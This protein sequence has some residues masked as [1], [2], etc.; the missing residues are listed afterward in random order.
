MLSIRSIALATTA[1]AALVPAAASANT[2][3]VSKLDCPGTPEW[4][5]QDAITDASNDAAAARIEIGPGVFSGNIVVPNNPAGLEIVGSGPESTIFEATVAGTP[6]IE[7][8][9]ASLSQLG[10]HLPDV[11]GAGP[12]A[13]DLVDGASADHIRAEIPGTYPATAVHIE[14]GGSLSHAYIDAGVRAAVNIGGNKGYADVAIT[15]TFLRGASPITVMDPQHTVVGRRDHLVVTQDSSFGIGVA[16]GTARLE[17]SVVD[18]RG[19]VNASAIAALAMNGGPATVEGRHLTVLADG[20]GS[21]GVTAIS[22]AGQGLAT[23]ALTDSVLNGVKL[24]AKRA[25]GGSATIAAKRVDTWPAA[26][27]DVAGATFSDEGSFS[28]DPL[29][30]ADLVPGAGSPAIDAAA[31][32]GD[33][34]SDTDLAGNARALD[35][36]GNCDARPDLGAYEAPAGTCVPPVP[37]APPA[38]P[39]IV[40]APP[41]VDTVAPRVTKLSVA[42]RRAVRFTLTETARVTVRIARGHHKP[43]FLHRAAAGGRVTLKLKHVLRHGR[44]AIRVTAVDAAGNRSVPAVA[45]RRI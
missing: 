9:G 15:D 32:L 4:T 42:H 39:S 27:D 29:L 36:D 43:L 38:P 16:S 20:N 25:G 26:P 35:G 8:H 21:A 34:E 17:D 7:A 1:A 22:I 10:F 19:Q 45:R 5:I 24:R 12:W 18:L 3:C 44:Y 23:A 14:N 37:P 31:P 6:V 33:G 41:A 40:P 30:T 13:L 2:Y 28:A 11:G